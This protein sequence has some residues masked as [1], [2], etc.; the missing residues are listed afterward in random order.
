MLE[1]SYDQINNFI[2]PNFLPLIVS[3]NDIIG[4][5]I[6]TEKYNKIYRLP[7]KLL[8]SISL[9]ES[10]VIEGN[11]VNSWPW[12]LNVNGKSKYFDNKKETLSFS[13][14]SL[15]KNRNIDVG[16]MQIN[17][18][19]HGHNFKNLDHILN[20]EENVKYAAEFLKKLFKK[21]KSWNEAISRYH[22]SEPSRKKRY[23]KKVRNFWDKLRQRQIHVNHTSTQN[24]DKK[25]IEYFRQLLEKEKQH[26]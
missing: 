1:L 6:Y 22:S 11:T 23:L 15:Q 16:C 26:I 7:N 4:C 9:V 21:H 8:T 5:Q 24:L 20:P 14:E 2:F 25:K 18:K 19:F 17:Y 12:A 13:G 3:S 10:G